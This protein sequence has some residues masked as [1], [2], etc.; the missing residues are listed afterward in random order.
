MSSLTSHSA[1]EHQTRKGSALALRSMRFVAEMAAEN[2]AS[3][4]DDIEEET[5]TLCFVGSKDIVAARCPDCNGQHESGD[6]WCSETS[7]DPPQLSAMTCTDRTIGYS[8]DSYPAAAKQLACRPRGLA[9][10]PYRY[11]RLR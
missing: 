3:V 7:F 8:T 5:T 9:S 11:S 6:H 1:D 10:W 2:D 4:Q